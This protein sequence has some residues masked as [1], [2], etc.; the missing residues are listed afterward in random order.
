MGIYAEKVE[1]GGG[2]YWVIKDTD[3][4]KILS[5]GDTITHAVETYEVIRANDEIASELG[6]SFEDR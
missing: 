6:I 4:G 2:P 1:V 3:T 5:V